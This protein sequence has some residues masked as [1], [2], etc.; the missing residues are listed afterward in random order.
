MKL[1]YFLVFFFLQLYHA[2]HVP[3]PGNGIR[4]TLTLKKMASPATKI[5]STYNKKTINEPVIP[6]QYYPKNRAINNISIKLPR[7]TLMN[8]MRTLREEPYSTMMDIGTHIKEGS[9]QTKPI[10]LESYFALR[11][12][13]PLSIGTKP[14]KFKIVFDTGS[15]NKWLWVISTRYNS[16]N[17]EKVFN[18][19]RD[20]Y[21]HNLSSTYQDDV[22]NEACATSIVYAKGSVKGFCSIDTIT[23]N[24]VEIKSRSFTEATAVTT[25]QI[26]G[27]EDGV[28]GLQYNY[29]HE[30]EHIV[31]QVCEKLNGKRKFSFYFTNNL[32]KKQGSELML[33]GEDESKFYGPLTWAKE[34][35]PGKWKVL[36]KRYS[37]LYSIQSIY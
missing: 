20:V 29:G 6:L 22:K 27:G 21:N 15:P 13:G 1:Q 28:M 14:Q 11:Y 31:S 9:P 3:T 12:H 24:D 7:I 34:L 26:N 19:G 16:T 8:G 5:A 18:N 17:W 37:T 10:P 30:S 33:C 32:S 4:T 36:V 2:R 25:D 35:T 23:F